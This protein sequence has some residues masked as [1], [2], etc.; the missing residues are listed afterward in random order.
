MIIRDIQKLYDVNSQVIACDLHPGY[1][2]S[3]W[4]EQ[5][6]LPL[7]RVQHH[8]AHASSLAGEHPDIENWLV[9][10]WDGVGYGSDG[11]LWGGEALAGRPGDWNRVASFRPF[12]PGRRRQGRARALAFGSGAAVGCRSGFIR[13]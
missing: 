13:E 12:Q 10:T 5:Q 7:V 8:A 4:A 3:R 1:A 2:S 11:T 6:G 9:F